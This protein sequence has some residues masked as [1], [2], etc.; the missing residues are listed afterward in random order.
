MTVLY[1]DKRN[2]VIGVVT[3]A[4]VFCLGI[5]IGHYGRDASSGGSA[6]MSE[7]EALVDKIMNDQFSH[8]RDL[9]TQA[10][11]DVNSDNLRSYLKRLTKEPHIAGSK[12]DEEL[13]EYIK[14]A[15]I[16]MG[17]DRVELAEYD[18]Y[19]SWP[20]H[21]LITFIK[22]YIFQ[23]LRICFAFRPTLIK[24][25]WWMKMA[26]PFSRLS[27]KKSLYEQEMITRILFMP[28]MLTL[29]RLLWK[30]TWSTFIMHVSRI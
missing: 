14:D 11:E 3:L 17:L 8:E 26:A 10:L 13:V 1:L 24:S 28:L 22:R 25:T 6:G 12:Q 15:W 4:V 20:N 21:V 30:E 18:F 9:V 23:Q 16:D 7:A 5:V 19:L 27:T 29:L 2:M